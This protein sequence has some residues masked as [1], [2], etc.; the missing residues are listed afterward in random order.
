MVHHEGLLELD[1]IYLFEACPSV[2][3]YREQPRKIVYP[4][5]PRLRRY[6]PDF[7]LIFSSGERLLVEVKP[8]RS[9]EA[10]DVGHKLQVV[11]EYLAR[12]SEPFMVLTDEWL[13]T[14]PKQSNVRLLYRQ[15]PRVWPTSDACHAAVEYLLPRLPM[16]L[17]EARRLLA[18]RGVAPASLLFA[19]LLTC[20]LNEPI[21]NHTLVYFQQETSD[22]R[23]CIPQRYDL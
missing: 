15:T 22:A 4:D 12:S 11:R 18:P 16:P 3:R 9:L 5:G 2:A 1:A 7:E 17:L 14:E 23:I 8:T 6:T 10:Q 19:G 20:Q 21:T 13:R